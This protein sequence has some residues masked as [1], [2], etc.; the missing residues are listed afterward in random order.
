MHC[1]LC[2]QRQRIHSSSLMLCVDRLLVRESIEKSK[3][4]CVALRESGISPLL[5]QGFL[6]AREERDHLELVGP[7][8]I[9]QRLEHKLIFQRTHVLFPACT[10]GGSWLH[11]TPAPG[12]LMQSSFLYGPLNTHGTHAHRHIYIHKNKTLKRLKITCV[13]VI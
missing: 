6:R 12:D 8:K 7:G 3:P 2:Q 13:K 11:V 9:V 4:N 10:A 1:T 5:Q